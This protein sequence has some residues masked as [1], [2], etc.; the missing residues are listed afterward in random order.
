[1]SSLS[2]IIPE[3]KIY[4]DPVLYIVI[5]YTVL[6]GCLYYFYKD[7]DLTQNHSYH[8]SHMMYKKE[9]EIRVKSSESPS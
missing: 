9:K 7:F 6:I 4:S 3:S 1:M 5:T 8:S 2:N